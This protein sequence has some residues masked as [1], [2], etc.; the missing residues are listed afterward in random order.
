ML[1]LTIKRFIEESA[2]FISSN[3]D[4][5]LNF[6]INFKNEEG[7]KREN[8]KSSIVSLC[9]DFWTGKNS[10]GYL[11]VTATILE[12][13]NRSNYL[14]GLRHVEHPHTESVVQNSIE[15]VISK[16][17]LLN[18]DNPK[19][20]SISTDNRSNKVA[21]IKNFVSF[22]GELENIEPSG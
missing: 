14:L 21:R 4:Y 3:I 5:C 12:N 16:F 18:L 20:L 7:S 13:A 17:G 19:I 15:K 11:G 6:N 1:C 22:P 10:I 2:I 8:R 9:A